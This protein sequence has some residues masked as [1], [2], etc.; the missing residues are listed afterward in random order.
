MHWWQKTAGAMSPS[1]SR[2]QLPGLASFS[3]IGSSR[4]QS[5]HNYHYWCFVLFY[6]N[7]SCELYNRKNFIRKVFILFPLWCSYGGRPAPAPPA[8][9]R[10]PDQSDTG[11]KCILVDWGRRR[12]ILPWRIQNF[13]WTRYTSYL[14][15]F[16]KQDE[17]TSLKIPKPSLWPK[18]SSNVTI[19]S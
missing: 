14:W 7:C 11:E 8:S 12:T 4:N 6:W 2:Q 13:I 5:S 10:G 15:S 3:L 18:L 19:R 17:E 9:D 16:Q 1:P